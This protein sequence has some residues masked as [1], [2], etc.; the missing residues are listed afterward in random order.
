M[1]DS[2][3]KTSIQLSERLVT[4]I[5]AEIREKL[6]E[7]QSCGGKQ[8]E[9]EEIDDALISVLIPLT[10]DRVILSV[11]E[12]KELLVDEAA[13]EALRIPLIP[14]SLISTTFFVGEGSRC[15]WIKSGGA[16]IL[17]KT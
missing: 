12:T 13:T 9:P 8:I 2:K 1:S 4:E 5:R 15:Y 16:S 10:Q 11:D 17:I 6:R 14:L 7:N 3:V